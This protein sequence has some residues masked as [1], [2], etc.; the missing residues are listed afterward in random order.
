MQKPSQQ[1]LKTI[2][3]AATLQQAEQAL[4]L[5]REDVG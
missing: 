4:E 3:G 5:F 1:I 2:Y